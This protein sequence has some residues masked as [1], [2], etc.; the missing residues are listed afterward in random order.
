M[1]PGLSEASV[2]TRQSV[3]EHTRAEEVPQK[4]ANAEN[5]LKH[6]FLEMFKEA[7]AG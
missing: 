5:R 2:M 3:A 1:T 7:A 6:G 4:G